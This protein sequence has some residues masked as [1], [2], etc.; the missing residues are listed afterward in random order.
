MED[1]LVYAVM[2]PIC[3]CILVFS[4]IG[5]ALAVRAKKKQSW[6]KLVNYVTIMGII[7]VAIPAIALTAWYV[8]MDYADE[9]LHAPSGTVLQKFDGEYGEAM[10]ALD[11]IKYSDT[12]IA[13]D[14]AF[15]LDIGEPA[16]AFGE[17]IANFAS[18]NIYTTA[19]ER[20][21]TFLVSG[22]RHGINLSALYEL[23][24]SRSGAVLYSENKH[25]IYTRTDQVQ[26]VRDW[27]AD[28]ANYEAQQ[29]YARNPGDEG[30]AARTLP[31]GAF[32]Q[33][34]N[35]YKGETY[36]PIPC[37]G[38]TQEVFL[39]AIS[40]DKLTRLECCLIYIDEQIYIAS[41][42]LYGG[43]LYFS[44]IVLPAALNAQLAEALFQ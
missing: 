5:L 21:L 37:T 28:P 22:K 16:L 11:G 38:E 29:V 32:A 42:G 20:L 30:Y 36:A 10:F 4:G 33:L 13:H 26:A 17:P 39:T 41:S 23:P 43:E 19:S 15:L 12:S 6:R 27:Y 8:F 7:G 3:L 1:F 25:A 40:K 9:T 24:E 44:G 18:S 31:P 14:E 34:W 35:L 2:I